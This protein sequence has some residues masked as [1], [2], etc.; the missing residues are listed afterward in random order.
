[1]LNALADLAL[2]RRAVTLRTPVFPLDLCAPS[3]LPVSH[4][5][6]CC[7]LSG[8]MRDA[9]Q[10]GACVRTPDSITGPNAAQ[11][12]GMQRFR[13]KHRAAQCSIAGADITQVLSRALFVARPKEEESDAS[14]EHSES[15][16][17]GSSSDVSDDGWEWA[18]AFSQACARKHSSLH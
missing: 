3:P 8:A 10:S 17:D 15:E 11:H 5:V 14:S 9:Q 13:V 6:A 4:W 2:A 1:M 16:G 18:G 12:V 7:R